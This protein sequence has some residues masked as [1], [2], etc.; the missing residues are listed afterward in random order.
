MDAGKQAAQPQ[1]ESE[2][3]R[4]TL[5]TSDE[6]DILLKPVK[7]G[8]RTRFVIWIMRRL[9]RPWL[10]WMVHGSYQRVARVQIALA[11]RVC[12][13]TSGLPLDYLVLGRVPGHFLGHVTDTGKT[14]ILYIHGGAFLMPAVPEV[15]VHMLG[16]MCRDL[17]A[18]GFMVDYRLAP[19]N[20]FPAALDDCQRAYEALLDLGYQPERIVVA[21]ESAGGNLA[22][23]LLQRIR[24]HGLPMPACVVPISPV[25]ELGRI[26][27]PPSRAMKMHSDP[28]LPIVALQRVDE[29]YAGDW[30][31][32]DPE[33]S[34]LYADCR[35]FPPM[36]LLASD[37][38]V[39]LDDTVLFAR[40]ARAAGVDVRF[41]VWPIVPHAFPLFSQWMPEVRQ[42]RDDIVAFIRAKVPARG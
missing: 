24:R 2:R 36:F 11:R 23:G 21:G 17:D 13:D 7:I 31:A 33:L 42:A 32:S 30:D 19:Y 5:P 4:A 10:A 25:T 3:I 26:H 20:K 41:E 12:K 34:P 15:H 14:A 18:V 8:L 39:L 29:M 9:L 38:E 40:R 35:G 1:V 37:A 27:A 22:L 16:R 6:R 28:L